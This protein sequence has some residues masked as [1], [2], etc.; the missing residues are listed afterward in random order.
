MY[1]DLQY[2]VTARGGVLLV[3]TH[4]LRHLHPLPNYPKT[5]LFC[6]SLQIIYIENTMSKSNLDSDGTADTGIQIQSQSPPLRSSARYNNNIDHIVTTNILNA[7]SISDNVLKRRS[8]GP[9]GSP[10]VLV[11]SSPLSGQI[12]G[13]GGKAFE[14]RTSQSRKSSRLSASLQYRK[15]STKPGMV[16]K[17][18]SAK[19]IDETFMLS[20]YVQKASGIHTESKQSFTGSTKSLKTKQLGQHQPLESAT[21]S[22]KSIASTTRKLYNSN[23]SLSA[24]IDIAKTQ[25]IIIEEGGISMERF[26]EKYE[27]NWVASIIKAGECTVAAENEKILDGFSPAAIVASDSLENLKGRITHPKSQEHLEKETTILPSNFGSS[28][29][30]LFTRQSSKKGFDLP[31]LDVVSLPPSPVANEAQSFS[32]QNTPDSGKKGAFSNRS[33]SSINMIKNSPL[34]QTGSG[35]SHDQKAQERPS[36]NK[37]YDSLVAAALKEEGDNILPLTITSTKLQ[38]YASAAAFSPLPSSNISSNF[39]SANTSNTSSSLNASQVASIVT[40]QVTSQVTSLTASG[41][42]IDENSVNAAQATSTVSKGIIDFKRAVKKLSLME[43]LK[44]AFSSKGSKSKRSVEAKKDPFRRPAGF[45]LCPI[46]KPS[47]QGAIEAYID[48]VVFKTV[49]E[50]PNAYKFNRAPPS[51][52]NYDTKRVGF[53]PNAIDITEAIRVMELGETPGQG[54]GSSAILPVNFVPSSLKIKQD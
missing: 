7:P 43:K 9:P 31:V 30:N 5:V 46:L 32:H 39:S 4:P 44:S 36:K 40:S 34:L 49:N 14:P 22:S 50:N 35:P 41:G 25:D 54:K 29:K 42:M 23:G 48:P 53:S 51:E 3:N 18:S 28:I 8:I 12:S 38:A 47:K 26:I 20:S 24:I 10:P 33:I 37:S 52:I 19:S 13:S 27:N 16:T 15:A 11:A 6:L 21:G 45:K 17:S 1:L 2:L